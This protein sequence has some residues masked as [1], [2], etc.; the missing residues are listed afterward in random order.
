MCLSV[1]IQLKDGKNML[2]VIRSEIRDYWEAGTF[3]VLYSVSAFPTNTFALHLNINV[4]C[5]T[6]RTHRLIHTYYSVRL[7]PC[8]PNAYPNILGKIGDIS[9]G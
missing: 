8:S 6:F 5:G 7:G 1:F 3:D 4:L 9:S 2:R